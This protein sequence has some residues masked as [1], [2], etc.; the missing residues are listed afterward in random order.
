MSKDRYP[1]GSIKRT[2]NQSSIKKRI[3]AFLLD[4]IGH[5]VTREML[6]EVSKDP[7]SGKE[8]EN[9]HQRLSELRTDEGYTILSKR[10]LSFLSVDEYILES[11][12]KRPQASGRVTP[13]AETWAA[14]LARA[15]NCCEWNEGGVSCGL[16]D[17]DND[18][19]GG[20]TVKLT[21]DHKTPH[22]INPNADPLNPEAWQALCGRHQITK[23]NYWDSN[24]GKINTVAI[25]QAAPRNDKETIYNNLKRYFGDE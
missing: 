22:S 12:Q 5:I 20:G 15:N 11:A 21:A 4:N 13:S 24:T 23:R 17:G 25:V 9:W 19:I 6:V 16:H 3:E 18:P 14:V 1:I 8:P 7:T 2:Y 10:D